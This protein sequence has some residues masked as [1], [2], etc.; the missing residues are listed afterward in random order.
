MSTDAF[1]EKNEAKN[2]ISN[3]I[4]GLALAMGAWL[5]LNTINPNL[6]TFNLELDRQ[7][8]PAPSGP[9]GPGSGGGGASTVPLSCNNCVTIG[10]PVAPGNVCSGGGSCTIN[11]ELNSKLVNLNSAYSGDFEVTE[12]WPPTVDH[13]DSCHRLGTCVDIGLGLQRNRSPQNNPQNIINF[14]NAANSSGLRAVFEVPNAQQRN[15]LISQGVPSGS[16]IV[17]SGISPH[18][19][20]YNN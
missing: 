6:T 9:T 20:V 4:W 10:V 16:I 14:I 19:S 17:V 11:G 12:A 7:A 5:I 18:F 1:G 13:R 15:N 3:A 8:I 2:T